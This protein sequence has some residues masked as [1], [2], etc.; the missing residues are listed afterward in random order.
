MGYIYIF[1]CLV[2]YKVYIGKWSG[3]HIEY[4]RNK[5]I[6]GHGNQH[7]Y[8]AIQKHGWENFIF[9]TLHENVPKE[10][11]NDLERK[12]IARFNCNSCCPGGW[13]YNK[14]D[15]GEGT[16]GFV[17]SAEHRQKISDALKGENNPMF[18]KPA[19]NKGKQGK[20]HTTQTRQKI[21]DAQ[22]GEKNHNYGKSPSVESRRKQSRSMRGKNVGKSRS[23]KT[24]Q[25]ISK[26]HRHPEYERARVFFYIDLANLP[27]KQKRK[28]LFAEF[29]DVAKV[30]LYKWAKDWQAELAT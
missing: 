17:Q 15:G 27:I 11:L 13:G 25:K 6:S 10:E 3:R 23:A 18:G 29:T 4:R 8:R 22:R 1:F 5:H 2:D 24:R 30:T 7:L 21:S 12:E 26:A 16:I 28:K 9:D 14:T 19:W 20:S